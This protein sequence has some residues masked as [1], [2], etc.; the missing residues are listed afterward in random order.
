[1]RQS[2]AA[3]SS[4]D[5]LPWKFSNAGSTALTISSRTGQHPKTLQEL[6]FA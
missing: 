1:M 4:H 3:S 2:I 6:T 5:L